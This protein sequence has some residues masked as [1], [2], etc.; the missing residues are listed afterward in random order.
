[1]RNTASRRL[2]RDTQL[3]RAST[4]ASS[5]RPPISTISSVLRARQIGGQDLSSAL[6]ASK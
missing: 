2:L 1:M 5:A 6:G 4:Q 3:G